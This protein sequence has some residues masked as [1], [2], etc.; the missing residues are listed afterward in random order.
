VQVKRGQ[1]KRREKENSQVA[2]Q[3]SKRK[4]ASRKN[5]KGAKF[6]KIGTSFFFAAFAV[7]AR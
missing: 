3:S 5:V 7:L 6:G 2:R 4:D 1:Q